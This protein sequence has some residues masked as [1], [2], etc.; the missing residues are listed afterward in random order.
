VEIR[1]AVSG[2][3]LDS[4][5]VSAFAGG[6]YWRWTL[7]GHVTMKVTMTSAPN[8]VVSGLF[9]DPPTASS[10]PVV[11]VTAPG[12]GAAFTAPATLTVTA[13][14]TDADGV[15]RVEFYQAAGQAAP[16][17]IGPAV[18]TPPYSIGWNGVAVGS[19]TLTAKAYDVLGNVATSAPVHI[20]V[21]AGG[22]G[23]PSAQFIGADTTTQGSWRGV[24]G[25]DGY[26]TAND[27][28]NLPAYATVTT[29]GAELYTWASST[30]DVRA[31]EKANGSGRLAATW[32]GYGFT[33]DV[34]LTD[35]A[36][37]QVSLY[38]VDWDTRG[39]AETV[40]IRDAVSGALLDSRAVSA[41]AGGQYWRWTLSGHVTIRVTMTNPPNAVV[42][43]IFFR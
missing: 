38:L 33:F 26:Q 10:T 42:S 32:Y 27:A 3:V 18:R 9:F 25:A 20:T 17:L 11:T 28:T 13:T 29:T 30:T 15:D 23:G 21:A 43:G 39:R 41:F 1:D 6:Q 37:H 2:A 35:G 12:E 19:Y 8:A 5:T 40:E 34:N 24:Y 4:R 7:S 16:V 22:G 36:A 14:A 31:L